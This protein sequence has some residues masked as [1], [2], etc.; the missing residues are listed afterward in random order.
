MRSRRCARW[1]SS[2]GPASRSSPTR[3]RRSSPGSSRPAACSSPRSSAAL[4]GCCARRHRASPRPRPRRGGCSRRCGCAALCT[5]QNLV[6]AADTRDHVGRRRL[7][8]RRSRTSR[9]SSTAPSSSPARTSRSTG[10]ARTCACSRAAARSCCRARTRAAASEDTANFAN[11][12]E[13]VRTGSSRSCPMRRPP[14]RMDVPCHQNDAPEHQRA[15]RRGRPVRPGAG[16][17]RRAIREHLRDFVAIIALVVIG[18]A[19]TGVILSQQRQP[20]PSWI[21]FLGDDQFEL[22][23][24]I[25]TAQAVTPGQGQTV[26]MAGV[27]VGDIREV[28]LEDGRAIV[29]MG[30]DRPY[31]ELIHEDATV[32][33]RPRTGLQDMTHGARPGRVGRDRRGGVHDPARAER[34]ERPAST[35]S[36]RR[37]TATPSNYLKLLI[38]G[39]AKGL[40]GRGEE[41]SAGL[42]RFEPLG[43]DLARI[44][45]RLAKRRAEHQPRDLQLRRPLR[46][47]RSQ[48]HSPGRLRLLAEPGVRGVRGPGGEPARDAAGAALHAERDPLRPGERPD[49]GGGA[50]P[51][52]RGA[53]PGGAG[54]RAGPGGR[55]APGAGEPGARSADQIRPFTRQVRKPLRHLE[56]G[57]QAAGQDGQVDAHAPSAT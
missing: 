50:R 16:S 52:V 46:G 1:R 49:P 35:R 4:R 23:V 54:V 38:Q 27:E 57:R 2:R 10:T 51:G 13:V 22:K 45:T 42:R 15:R 20:Y 41:L 24:E 31:E 6:P 30:V 55:A 5:T 12:V 43:R 39:G 48:R 19:V 17:M 3:S 7:E 44:N 18:L 33:M 8:H 11:A 29:T 40:G 47:A 9:S 36:S 14:F 56:P 21:P 34:A 32:L 25:A 53:D 28:E 37:S 26:N